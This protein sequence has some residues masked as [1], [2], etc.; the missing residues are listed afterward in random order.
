MSPAPEVPAISPSEAQQRLED[1][2]VILDVREPDEWDSGHAPGAMWIPLGDLAA[3]Q[4]E[5]VADRPIVVVC[6]SGGRSARATAALLQAGYDATNLAGGMQAWAA[7]G[8]CVVTD[9]GAPG[10]VT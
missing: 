9:Q 7:A 4:D 8:L 2:A 5:V 3:R 1:G 6:R 10:A